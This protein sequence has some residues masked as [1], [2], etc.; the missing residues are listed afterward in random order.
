MKTVSHWDALEPFGITALTGE[1]C[2]LGYRLLCNI[3]A[4]G[5]RIVERCLGVEIQSQ[6]W[7]HGS[8]DDPHVA[9]IMLTRGDDRTARGIRPAG[10]RL[11]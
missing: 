8:D 7:N 2:S 3:T 5:K 11:P 4:T 9:S 10:V 6:N 1:A